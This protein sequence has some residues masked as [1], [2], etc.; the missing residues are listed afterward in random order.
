MFLSHDVTTGFMNST[1]NMF[2]ET[3]ADT[4]AGR[5]QWGCSGVCRLSAPPAA[6]TVTGWVQHSDVMEYEISD[7]RLLI[8]QEHFTAQPAQYSIAD[9]HTTFQMTSVLHSVWMHDFYFTFTCNGLLSHGGVGTFKITHLSTCS[10]SQ[11][12]NVTKYIYLSTLS[13]VWLI[14][15]QYLNCDWRLLISKVLMVKTGWQSDWRE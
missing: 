6:Q 10:T 5:R 1:L 11:W 13:Y 7:N 3:W 4:W 12:W 15:T 8:Y 9:T 14:V 2:Y